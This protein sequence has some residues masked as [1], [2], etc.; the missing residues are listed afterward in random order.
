MTIKYSESRQNSARN[1]LKRIILAD[2]NKKELKRQ[3]VKRQESLTTLIRTGVVSASE[4]RVAIILK[5]A[6]SKIKGSEG[7]MSQVYKMRDTLFKERHS[8]Y[9]QCF[10]K[11]NAILSLSLWQKKMAE[12]GCDS[13]ICFSV[14]WDNKSLREIDKENRKRSGWARQ[15]FKQGLS[16]FNAVLG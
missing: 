3:F 13:Q 1:L 11:Q 10:I 5:R 2:E 8:A 14:L 4:G 15:R 16:C 7:Q 6:I 12:I 9:D